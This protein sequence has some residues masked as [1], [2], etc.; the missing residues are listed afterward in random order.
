MYAGIS[1][2][3]AAFPAKAF[4][5]DAIRARWACGITC[6][7]VFCIDEQVNATRPAQL[8]RAGACAR[9][10]ALLARGSAFADLV[11][12]PTVDQ[13]NHQ[14]DAIFAACGQ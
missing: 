3:G 14:I 2:E 10:Y 11:A 12:F 9:A 8:G 1:A 5:I 4:S 6:A 7:A 13:I